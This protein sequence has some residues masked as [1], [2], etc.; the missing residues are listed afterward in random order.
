NGR[1]VTLERGQD[2]FFLPLTESNVEKP[3]LVDLRY[4][5]PGD[6]TMLPLPEFPENPAIQKVIL[7][8][9]LPDDVAL[10]GMEGP[11]TN[12]IRW[13]DDHTMNW[14]RPYYPQDDASLIEALKQ[15][16]S[17]SSDPNEG[18]ET[19]G[20]RYVFSTLRP[21]GVLQLKKLD[22]TTLT[23]LLFAVVVLGG[24]LL[25]SVDFRI[26]VLV[27]GGCIAAVVLCGV[28]APLFAVQILDGYLAAALAIVVVTWIAAFFYR[29]QPWAKAS[30][31]A[32]PM[33]AV[34]RPAPAPA[35]APQPKPP[36]TDVP[37][38]PFAPDAPSQKTSDAPA[39]DS[40]RDEN[41]EGGKTNA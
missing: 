16:I 32:P 41:D 35:P 39:D 18:F 38:S 17:V 12:E 4:T 3:V 29:H 13:R 7:C 37:S 10:I 27:V 20:R 15:G 2:G 21:T 5:L 31:P 22:E 8:V 11:W 23:A 25:L 30:P 36:A 34:L 40:A 33:D 19:D 24:V 6:G 26:R 14:W 9:Y 1:P 28:F